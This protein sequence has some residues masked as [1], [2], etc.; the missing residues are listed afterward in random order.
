MATEF[1]HNAPAREQLRWKVLGSLLLILAVVHVVAEWN[2][3]GDFLIYYQASADILGQKDIYTLMYGSAHQLPYLASPVLALLLAPF[4]LLPYAA[5]AAL[6]KIFSLVLLYRIWINLERY[7]PLYRLSD[8]QYTALVIGSFAS[9]CFVLYRNLHMVQFTIF[10]LFVMLEGMRLTE[11]GKPAA[12]ASLLAL[13][14]VVK[15]LPVVMVPYLLYRR[16]FGAALLTLLFTVLLFFLPVVFG[17][18]DY[19]TFLN[20]QWLVSINPGKEIN[21]LD[22]MTEDIHTLAAWIS[23]L[24]VKNLSSYPGAPPYRRHL[25]DLPVHTVV[26]IIQCTRVFFAG[27]MLYFLRSRPFCAEPN[28][29]K[30]LWELAYLFMATALIFPQQRTY[31]FLLVLPALF[32]LNVLLFTKLNRKTGA[33]KAWL[34]G[35]YMTALVVF[36]LELLLGSFRELYWYYKTMTYAVLLFVLVLAV[37]RPP[38]VEKR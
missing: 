12:G 7:F 28:K 3:V 26:I 8:R 33:K 30:R 36:N 32:Y 38:A 1:V 35:I 20:G 2:E 10:L 5:A 13:G 27:F 15:L 29:Q 19:F 18:W 24:L 6:W 25:A 22:Y 23:S 37:I 31:A 14:I 9:V 4:S 16:Y 17:G 34:K 11:L 21:V